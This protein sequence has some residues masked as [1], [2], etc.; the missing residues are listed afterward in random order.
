MYERWTSDEET[1]EATKFIAERFNPKNY[2]LKIG[3]DEKHL[4][5]HFQWPEHMQEETSTELKKSE[6]GMLLLSFPVKCRRILDGEI[7]LSIHELDEFWSQIQHI[8]TMAKQDIEIERPSQRVDALCG[9]IA[10]L[11]LHHR[12]WLKEFPEKEEW[13][14]KYIF[15]TL[16]E[17]PQPSSFDCEESISGLHWDAF[18]GEAGVLFLTEEPDNENV[19]YVAARGVMAYHEEATGSTLNRAFRL[20]E[21]LGEEFTRLL[22][23]SL[24][25]T[26]LKYLR[27]REHHEGAEIEKWGTWAERLFRYYVA[28]QVPSTPIPIG[29]LAKAGSRLYKRRHHRMQCKRYP[30]YVPQRLP[31]NGG[32]HPS[33]LRKSLSWLS[34]ADINDPH[35]P[36]GLIDHI[37][38]A[39][40]EFSISVSSPEDDNNTYH[41]HD[42]PNE[43][44]LWVFEILSSH[45][46]KKTISDESSKFW[47]P[48]FDVGPTLHNWPKF[49]LMSWFRT[50]LQSAGCPEDFTR[51]WAAMIAYVLEH[52]KWKETNSRQYYDC[53]EV[54]CQLMGMDLEVRIVGDVRFE[55][56]LESLQPYYDRWRKLWLQGEHSLMNFCRLLTYPAA[57]PL[58]TEGV[59]WV[60]EVLTGETHFGSREKDLEEALLNMLHIFWAEHR[61]VL[62]DDPS[63]KE[64]FLD[65]LTWLVQ[66]Q[67]S[68][69][70]ELQDEVVRSK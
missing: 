49:F 61:K 23:F 59:L 27:P 16:D 2:E 11:F 51:H 38:L 22:N 46:L 28:G 20:R 40:L 9:G 54:I 32:M 13:C 58:R 33:L 48:L 14:I 25:W 12:D 7:S 41:H 31:W 52:P 68:G 62:Q 53:E 50:G 55:K 47:K 34:A 63:L 60:R 57:R 6:D 26:T 66:R 43:F 4:E 36:P 56:A 39:L 18:A 44:D 3:S 24:L 67:N 70:L 64:A 1:R 8:F 45:I 19:R 10:V 69:A 65:I 37:S 35:L 15:D 30:E 29:R 42:I 17:P 21:K 5:I